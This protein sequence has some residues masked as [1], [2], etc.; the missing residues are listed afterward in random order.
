MP[1]NN[2]NN[3]KDDR[4]AKMRESKT[5]ERRASCVECVDKHLAAAEVAFGEM[6]NGYK[7]RRMVIGHLF[8]AEDE[9]QQWPRT[10]AE[11]RSARVNFQAFG[12]EP[13]WDAI[14]EL[15]KS[16]SSESNP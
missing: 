8:H 9:A 13:N 1:C 6:K 3:R 11:I 12:R 16:E 10:H 7:F 14:D 15:F 5:P 4:A 2:C